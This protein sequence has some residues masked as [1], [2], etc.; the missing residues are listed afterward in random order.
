MIVLTFIS[1]FL[2]PPVI[3]TSAKDYELN[4]FDLPSHIKLM[5]ESSGKPKPTIMWMKNGFDIEKNLKFEW[6]LFSLYFNLFK[7]W[8]EIRRTI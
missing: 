7:N 6:I 8:V 1:N 4:L 5:C 3:L 2:E